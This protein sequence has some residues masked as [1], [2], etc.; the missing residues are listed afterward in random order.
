M[1][2]YTL[3][4]VL[5]LASQPKTDLFS[6]EYS[7]SRFLKGLQNHKDLCEILNHEPQ[8]ALATDAPPASYDDDDDDDPEDCPSPP[9]PPLSAQALHIRDFFSDPKNFQ[10]LNYH[11]RMLQST[12]STRKDVAKERWEE[13]AVTPK[14]LR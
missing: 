10:S 12:N 13:I 3:A 4:A 2:L 8:A 6:S 11:Q 7:R 14:L 1:Q 9:Q 5:L